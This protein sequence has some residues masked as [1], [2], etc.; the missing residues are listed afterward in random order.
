MFSLVH[1]KIQ[2]FTMWDRTYLLP[3]LQTCAWFF[4]DNQIYIILDFGKKLQE[5]HHS[6]ILKIAQHFS[7]KV[8]KDPHLDQR[9]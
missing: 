6:I 2:L 8:N 3:D 4:H 5:R 1:F 9:H 7:Y